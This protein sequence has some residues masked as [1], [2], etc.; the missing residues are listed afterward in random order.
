[1][2]KKDYELIAESLAETY[3]FY[4]EFGGDDNEQ[5]RARTAIYQA[6]RC[7]ADNLAKDNSKFSRT[8]FKIYF[9]IKI[10]KI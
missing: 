9:E 8:A 5:A 6:V 10:G 3:N 7:M 4:K 2:T 1:M